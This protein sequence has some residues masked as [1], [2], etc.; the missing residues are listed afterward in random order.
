[1]AFNRASLGRSRSTRSGRSS[2]ATTMRERG[3][4]LGKYVLAFLRVLQLLAAVVI[5]GY[6]ASNVAKG[7]LN[8]PTRYNGTSFVGANSFPWGIPELLSSSPHRFGA[9][10]T[11]P[12]FR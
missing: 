5:I 8:K 1:M 4:T 7:S 11:L 9:H 6:Y 12:A 10:S 3:V 2:T